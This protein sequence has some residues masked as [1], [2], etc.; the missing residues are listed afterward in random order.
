MKTRN[1]RNEDAVSPVVGVMLMLVVTIVIAAVVSAY[2]GG[3]TGGSKKSPQSTVTATPDL[4]EHL[5]AFEHTGG[6]AFSLDE[7]EVV[8]QTK[9]QKVALTTNDVGTSCLAF[10][11]T[12]ASDSMVKAGERFVV[13]GSDP[14]WTTGITY[15]PSGGTTTLQENT[16]VTWMIVDRPSARTIASGEMVV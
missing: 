6:S 9:D 16:R 12:G 5:I 7:I 15:G 11:K 14:G 8:F 13:R 4:Q 2:A 3:M 1:S 10:N